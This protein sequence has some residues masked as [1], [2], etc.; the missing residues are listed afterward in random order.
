MSLPRYAARRDGNEGALIRIAEEFNGLW[1]PA[2][3]FD[4]WLWGRNA[5]ASC[6]ASGWRLIEVKLP[7][8]EGTKKEF[9]RA[10]LETIIRLNERQARWHVIRTEDDILALL[11]ARRTA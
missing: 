10:Q 3:P 5:C 4:G 8:R 7:E 11:G 1:I 9:T 2:P 6:G